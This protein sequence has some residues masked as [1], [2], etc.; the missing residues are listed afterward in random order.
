MSVRLHLQCSGCENTATGKLHRDFETIFN[1]SNAYGF[2]RWNLRPEVPDGWV[3][4]DP[5]TNI[6]YC[7][8]CADEIWGPSVN[9]DARVAGV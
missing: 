1:G 6:T 4:F 3:L 8:V 9:Q 2:G 5:Y 7:P